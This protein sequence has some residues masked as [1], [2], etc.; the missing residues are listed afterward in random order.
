MVASR[1]YTLNRLERN[2]LTHEDALKYGH[3]NSGLKEIFWLY[4]LEGVEDVSF[5]L[6][7]GPV[8]IL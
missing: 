4:I 8:E 3:R 2:Q 7:V 6:F 1:H 5:D